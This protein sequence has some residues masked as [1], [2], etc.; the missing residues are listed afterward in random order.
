[1]LHLGGEA[2]ADPAAA[3]ARNTA[4]AK[5][6]LDAHKELRKSF[7]G[8]WVFAESAGHDPFAT[9]QSMSDIP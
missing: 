4:A 2:L 8:V 9:E 3:R 6:I 7:D 5:A 1:M